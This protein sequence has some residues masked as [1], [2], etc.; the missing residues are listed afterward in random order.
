M[1]PNEKGEVCEHGTGPCPRP[2]T[3]YAQQMPRPFLAARQLLREQRAIENTPSPESARQTAVHL[4]AFSERPNER[5]VTHNSDVDAPLI[6]DFDL[7]LLRQ[8]LP[9]SLSLLGR[10]GEPKTALSPRS[11]RGATK[12]RF[13]QPNSPTRIAVR[14]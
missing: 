8:L 4:V 11:L 5:R 3:V 6:P 2:V 13:I 14:A 10:F 9:F 1:H 7:R 12:K